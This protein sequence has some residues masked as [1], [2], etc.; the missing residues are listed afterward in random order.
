MELS[1]QGLQTGELVTRCTILVSKQEAG[2]LLFSSAHRKVTSAY[3]I[4]EKAS[5]GAKGFPK[6]Q[7]YWLLHL[8]ATRR[9]GIQTPV[10]LWCRA[11][12]FH[13]VVVVFLSQME[14]RLAAA[15]LKGPITLCKS[16]PCQLHLV[17]LSSIT[18]TQQRA[19]N[20][21]CYISAP[22]AVKGWGKHTAFTSLIVKG[23]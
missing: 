22:S 18:S 9:Q 13:N 23:C 3:M 12:V 15:P 5:R 6:K 4:Q 21:W 17:K 20:S 8:Q 16:L 11:H 19:T 7:E 2:G 1:S 10:L 14:T